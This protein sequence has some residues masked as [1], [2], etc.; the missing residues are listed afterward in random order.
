[1]TPAT[2]FLQIYAILPRTMTLGPYLRFAIWVQGCPRNC[3]GCMS[4]DAKSF[5]S[6]TVINIGTLADQVLSVPEIEGITVS[7]GEPFMQ[8]RNLSQL[9][10]QIRS[11]RDLGLIVYTG[12]T[13]EELQEKIRAGEEEVQKLLDY[14]DLLI[15]GPYIRELDDG[16]S[17]RGSANQ[18]VHEMT[19]RYKG[20]AEK[21][22][23][24]PGRNMELH[25]LEDKVFLAGIPGAESLDQW[26]RKKII[27]PVPKDE[28]QT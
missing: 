20:A 8:A 17:L 18:K 24:K 26:Q 16:L 14:T 22:Y 3:P 13:L 19:E 12:F 2:G 5:D 10:E 27:I 9:M 6:G 4:P 25:L 1:M 23:G 21:Y 28:F 15:D 7:G 11:V